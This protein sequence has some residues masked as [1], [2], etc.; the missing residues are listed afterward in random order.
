ME[1][2]SG[3]MRTKVWHDLVMPERD[4]RVLVPENFAILCNSKVRSH[5][6]IDVQMLCCCVHI[7]VTSATQI[8]DNL[9]A[10]GHSGTELLHMPYLLTPHNMGSELRAG[11]VINT[12]N[13]KLR[14][15]VTHA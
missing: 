10:G 1:A 6:T 8:D 5:F 9:G 4:K 13:R 15:T 2:C 14:S 12:T 3:R 11:K 7:L